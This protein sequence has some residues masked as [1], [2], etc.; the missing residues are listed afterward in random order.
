MCVFF[1]NHIFR[2]S[3]INI[4]KYEIKYLKKNK[5]WF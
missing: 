1:Y 2:N 3:N 5:L 4:K